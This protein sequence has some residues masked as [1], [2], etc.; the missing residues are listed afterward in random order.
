MG[1]ES[2]VLCDQGALVWTDLELVHALT[3]VSVAE[4][5]DTPA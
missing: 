1:R 4:T 5:C 2:T 3:G